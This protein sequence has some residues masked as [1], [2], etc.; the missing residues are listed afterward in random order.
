MK[1]IMVDDNKKDLDQENIMGLCIRKI[2][3]KVDLVE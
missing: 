1:V 3:V 2:L